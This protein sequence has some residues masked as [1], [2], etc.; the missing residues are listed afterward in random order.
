MDL[1]PVAILH[2]GLLEVQRRSLIVIPVMEQ[3]VR[4]LLRES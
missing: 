3:L 2:A 1:D 4:K